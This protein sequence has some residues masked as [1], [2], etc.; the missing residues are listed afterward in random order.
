MSAL[1][2][3][4]MDFQGTADGSPFLGHS[5]VFVGEEKVEPVEL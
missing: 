2:K 5:V 3:K 1:E 4:E